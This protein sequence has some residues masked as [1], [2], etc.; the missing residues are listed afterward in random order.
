M[1]AAA[2]SAAIAFKSTIAFLVAISAFVL[3]W[4]VIYP[5][6]MGVVAQ[7]DKTGRLAV[8]AV[9]SQMAGA[10]AGPA[11]GSVLVRTGRMIG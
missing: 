2:I 6:F 8:F 1:T 10:A 7:I 3:A 4:F 5:F 9:F 11:L